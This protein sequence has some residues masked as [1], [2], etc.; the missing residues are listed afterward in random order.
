MLDSITEEDLFKEI[1]E[2]NRRVELTSAQARVYQDFSKILEENRKISETEKRIIEQNGLECMK[3]Y[4]E[5]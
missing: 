3:K 5:I 2:A 1:R 4:F